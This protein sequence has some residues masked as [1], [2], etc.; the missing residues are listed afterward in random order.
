MLAG[1]TAVRTVPSCR[2][3]PGPAYGPP[4]HWR[5]H[6]ACAGPGGGGLEASGLAGLGARGGSSLHT[7]DSLHCFDCIS[8][9]V[10]LATT[11]CT[12]HDTWL[13]TLHQQHT[14]RNGDGRC[15]LISRPRYVGSARQNAVVEIL[16][17]ALNGTFAS[18]RSRQ[19]TDSPPAAGPPDDSDS[20]RCLARASAPQVC[21]T[22]TPRM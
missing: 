4:R 16:I 6:R 15:R 19:P 14:I 10:S 20:S 21:D 7:Q 5:L 12:Q 17:E 9:G 22:D 18:A 11:G 8:I 2:Q 13:C 1:R 3:A